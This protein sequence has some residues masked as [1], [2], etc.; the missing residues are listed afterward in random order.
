MLLQLSYT[1]LYVAQL[2]ELLS[3][4]LETILLTLGPSSP[5]SPVK[6]S[7]NLGN[8]SSLS[9]KPKSDK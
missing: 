8:C 1:L 3:F 6:S 7:T 2:K 5:N 4:H 9:P